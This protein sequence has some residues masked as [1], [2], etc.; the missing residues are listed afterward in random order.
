M[1]TT[2]TEINNMVRMLE[3]IRDENCIKGGGHFFDHGVLGR[4]L[5]LTGESIVCRNCGAL[6]VVRKAIDNP[7]VT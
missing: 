7:T 2:M 3:S 5:G 1:T 4:M 6:N